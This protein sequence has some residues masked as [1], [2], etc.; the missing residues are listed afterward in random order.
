ML[1]RSIPVPIIG[2]GCG[3]DTCDG[4]IAVVT[5]LVG[6]FPWFVPA[7]AK[8]EADTAGTIREAAARYIA[9]VSKSS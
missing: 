9:R 3:E 1:T 8:P 6:S 5:D 7:F 2:I 4:E